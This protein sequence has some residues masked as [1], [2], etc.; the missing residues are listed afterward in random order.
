MAVPFSTDVFRCPDCMAGNLHRCRMLLRGILQLPTEAVA[1]DGTTDVYDDDVMAMQKRL[2]RLL[3]YGSVAPIRVRPEDYGGAELVP[4]LIA[5]KAPQRFDARNSYRDRMLSTGDIMVFIHDLVPDDDDPHAVRGQVKLPRVVDEKNM[6][7]IPLGA[8]VGMGRPSMQYLTRVMGTEHWWELSETR[9]QEAKSMCLLMASRP[10]EAYVA[11]D[12]TKSIWD[13]EDRARAP[14]GAPHFKKDQVVEANVRVPSELR[15][16][17]ALMG[18]RLK[19]ASGGQSA[20]T[21]RIIQVKFL[22]RQ[23]RW[24]YK[25]QWEKDCR[26]SSKKIA[27]SLGLGRYFDEGQVD[28]WTIREV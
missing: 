18:G 11:S 8:F 16:E 17:I 26:S 9:V 2:E 3:P 21:G 20:I 1:A 28:L 13:K 24:D 6:R 5:R 10:S 27:K 12:T 22:N 14:V 4:V 23:R 25:I 19:T 15:A 7:A